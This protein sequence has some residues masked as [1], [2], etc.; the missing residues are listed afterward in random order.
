M[1]AE[2]ALA[3]DWQIRDI[4][5]SD[6]TEVEELHLILFPV[7]YSKSFYQSLLARH[8]ISLVAVDE[9]TDKIIGIA[10]ARETTPGEGYI[11]TIGVH[12]SHR[13]RKLATH[14]LQEIS[15]DLEQSWGCKR[16]T[17]HVKT[18]N[19][20]AIAFY[21]KH[22]FQITQRLVDH[23]CIENQNYDA[24]ELIRDVAPQ[25]WLSGLIGRF[26]KCFW[27]QGQLPDDP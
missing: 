23:Y 21:Q 16:T 20:G 18:D 19:A 8:V 11:M 4:R 5:A 7:R 1:Q 6:L 13:R 3:L 25:N 12:P 24:F 27:K 14:L 26:V 15:K 9:G 17:L 22:G 2:D 10:T